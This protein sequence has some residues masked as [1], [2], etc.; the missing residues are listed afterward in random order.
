MV[1]RDDVDPGGWSSVTPDML[2]IPLDV[3]MFR[4]CKFIGMTSRKSADL[5]TAVEI[6]K[7]F[8][9]INP[10]DPVKYDFAITRLGIRD[11]LEQS[12]FI[13]ACTGGVI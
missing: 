4:I 5:Q 9:T 10:A 8:R 2:L 1:R 6:T 11:E 13:R 12:G 3:H 7:N